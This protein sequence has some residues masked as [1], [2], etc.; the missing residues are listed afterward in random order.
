MTTVIRVATLGPAVTAKD[1]PC[2]SMRF[3][4]SCQMLSLLAVVYRGGAA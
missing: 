1:T 3:Y 2:T 4:K